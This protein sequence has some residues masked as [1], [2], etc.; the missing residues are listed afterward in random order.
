MPNTTLQSD[1]I[2]ANIRTYYILLSVL[3]LL[4]FGNTLRNGYN[5]DDDLVTQHHRFTSKGFAGLQDIVSNSYY[6]NNSDI[7]FGYRPVTHITFAIEHQLFGESPFVSHFINVILYLISTLVLFHLL[8][9]WFGAANFWLP[10]IAAFLFAVHP[11]H[12]EV[13]ASIKN[14]DEILALL[15]A[16]IS[17][18]AFHSYSTHKRWYQLLFA[19]VLF[20]IALLS[21]KSVYPLVVIVPLVLYLLSSASSRR[22]IISSLLMILP[23]A[24]IT[25]DFIWLSALFIFS[26]TCILLVVLF[27]LAYIYKNP[28]YIKK[29][30]HLLHISGIHFVIIILLFALGFYLND[31]VCFA[32]ATILFIVTTIS[33]PIKYGFLLVVLNSAIAYY[34]NYRELTYVV[35]LHASYLAYIQF[36]S[37]FRDL[38]TMASILIALGVFVMLV[39]NYIPL[40]ILLQ[41]VLFYYLL[42]KKPLYGLAVAL[43]SITFSAYF[44]SVPIYQW[45]LLLLSLAGIGKAYVDRFKNDLSSQILITIFLVAPLYIVI[46]KSNQPSK[47]LHNTVS[48]FIPSTIQV[49]VS[50][51]TSIKSDRLKEGRSLHYIE[52]TLVA[53]HT[54]VEKYCTG[55]V[56]MGE[57]L[58]LMVFPYVLSFYYGFAKIK[59][60]HPGNLTVWLALIS[61]LFL[62]MLVFRY[63]HNSSAILAGFVWYITSIFLFSNCIELVA[64]MVGERL[65]YTAS[66]GF[67]IF[68]SALVVSAKPDLNFH[69][70]R[71]V[72]YFLLF[73]LVLFSAR[74]AMRNSQW[75]DPLTLMQNDIKH[76]DNSAQAHH[77]LAIN[78]L[79]AAGNEKN[80]RTSALMTEQAQVSLE[81]S[82]AVYPYF[83]NTQYDLARL[84]ISQSDWSRARQKLLDALLLDSTNLF[85]LESLAKV[86]FELNL[87]FD[88]ELYANQFISYLPYNENIHEILAYIM[89]TNGQYD[90]ALIYVQRGIK[91]FPSGKNLQPLMKDIEQKIAEKNG[92]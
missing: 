7:V 72:E 38:K 28:D 69:K 59:T 23:S 51:N 52:N 16:L 64:G 50:F 6:S 25:A 1:K 15:F 10:V 2:Y 73:I 40:L 56:T 14:R 87:P 21:K 54:L 18:H 26:V 47:I 3:V 77:L 20:I 67:C 34:Y 30:L 29:I 84:Y 13:V 79:Y 36:K 85:V 83:F 35:L 53:P 62:A 91:Y 24:W 58:K 22:I 80:P 63:R 68:F 90:K 11:V 44:F 41:L 86:C 81:K 48:A 31:W 60:A 43:V 65:A 74:S 12:T 9:K 45:L 49:P 57:Y 4:V 71:L 33:S 27:F 70:P 39:S 32:V 88:T 78:L 75:K 5:M 89:F 42:N 61:H 66:A 92:L 8:I 46:S 17:A 55:F 82:I 76:L 37:G 19:M